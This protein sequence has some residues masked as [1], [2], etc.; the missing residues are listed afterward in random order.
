M[1][2]PG[3][4]GSLDGGEDFVSFDPPYTFARFLRARC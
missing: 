2:T 3:T 1:G 4:N